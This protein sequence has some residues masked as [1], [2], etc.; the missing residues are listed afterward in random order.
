MIG[1]WANPQ[2]INF[3][4]DYTGLIFLATLPNG[5]VMNATVSGVSPSTWS[6]TVG[7]QT[8]TFTC[9]AEGLSFTATK[10]ADVK[11]KIML[12][13]FQVDTTATSLSFT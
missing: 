7:P 9:T 2:Y 3:P 8:A 1:N 12:N 10:S 4:V 11:F 6:S 5:N 13:K